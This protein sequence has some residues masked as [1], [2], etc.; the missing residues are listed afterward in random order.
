[1]VERAGVKS[2][3]E[4]TSGTGAEADVPEQEQDQIEDARG[5][6]GQL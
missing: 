2:I 3:H 5:H 1:M 4:S 6:I